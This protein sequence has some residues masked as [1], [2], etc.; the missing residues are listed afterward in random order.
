MGSF[1]SV[2]WSSVGKKVITGLTGFFLIGFV[3]AHLL[4][5]LTLLLG[6]GPF[7]GYAH[8]LE[9]L[10]HGWLIIVME[11]GL[12]AIFL[13]H[14]VAGVT[15]AVRDKSAAR[16]SRYKYSTNAGGKSRKT[17]ASRSMIVSGIVLA[18]FVILHVRLFKFGAHEIDAHGV[19]NLYKTVVTVFKNP[20]FAGFTVLSMILLGFH[21]RHGF[22]SAFQS[23]GWTKDSSLP[24]L[25]RIA[26][27][28][29]VILA[30]GFLVIAIMAF[31]TLDPHAV[32]G[33]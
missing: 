14:I 21:L 5:N 24:L 20:A 11:V 18:L 33:H 31:A 22:W 12:I 15:V 23:L 25:T 10:G 27:I 19:K 13:F 4:G 32:G 17:L 8:F 30:A 3:V 29:A 7:N 9:N 2:A 1:G 26:A 16:K 6:P 28:V